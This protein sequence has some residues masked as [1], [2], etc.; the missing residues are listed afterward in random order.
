MSNSRF[1]GLDADDEDCD[2]SWGPLILMGMTALGATVGL[3]KSTVDPFSP[4]EVPLIS[5]LP[6]TPD[7]TPRNSNFQWDDGDLINLPV[8]TTP[9][10]D[11]TF[12]VSPMLLHPTEIS[13]T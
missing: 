2:D 10:L 4:T 6:P 8:G 7:T 1:S 11:N 3:T 13:N 12:Q 9:P 5:V